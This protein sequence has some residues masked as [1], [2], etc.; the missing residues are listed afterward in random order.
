MIPFIQNSRKCKPI[1]TESRSVMAWGLGRGLWGVNGDAPYLDW[2]A[3]YQGVHACKNSLNC[4]LKLRH[5]IIC[6]WHLN[7]GFLKVGKIHTIKK[8]KSQ[9]QTMGGREKIFSVHAI[10]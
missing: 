9:P 5:F 4:P 7:E 3:C 1:M 2:N 8:M 6:K 10:W